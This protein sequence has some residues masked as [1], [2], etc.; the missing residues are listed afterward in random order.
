MSFRHCS[1]A[2]EAFLLQGSD[3]LA[4]TDSNKLGPTKL[5]RTACT[6]ELEQMC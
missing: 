1:R 3:V 5:C 6:D 2:T 4:S